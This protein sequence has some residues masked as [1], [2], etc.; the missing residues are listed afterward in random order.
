MSDIVERVGCLGWVL[1]KET[2]VGVGGCQ[3]LSLLSRFQMVEVKRQ[4]VVGYRL[5]RTCAWGG[6]VRVGERNVAR[7]RNQFLHV[8]G[9]VT[10]YET[11]IFFGRYK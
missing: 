11:R 9:C 7:A 4:A 1:R 3:H 10:F 2:R 5:V 6:T 8:I